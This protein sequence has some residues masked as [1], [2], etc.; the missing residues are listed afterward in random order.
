MGDKLDE[1]QDN[2]ERELCRNLIKN[3]D[4]TRKKLFSGRCKNCND[5]ISAKIEF[6]D[7][8]CSDDYKSRQR[9]K[10]GW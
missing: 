2:I 4:S 1:V 7:G 10:T 6:C 3:K 5:I 8:F 9:V